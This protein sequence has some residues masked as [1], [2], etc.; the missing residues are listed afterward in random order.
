MQIRDDSWGGTGT[1]RR[2][3]TS[4]GCY[5]RSGNTQALTA[6]RSR[7]HFPSR[8]LADGIVAV[9]LSGAPFNSD[10]VPSEA[11]RKLLFPGRGLDP[12]RIPG[13][14]RKGKSATPR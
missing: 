13:I 9:T 5:P 8:E 3:D 4:C 11:V 1:L 10:N 7:M 2:W 14:T 6:P 12:M